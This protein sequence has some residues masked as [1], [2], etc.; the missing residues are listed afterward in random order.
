[1]WR[2]DLWDSVLFNVHLPL[3]KEK[4]KLN[5]IWIWKCG[6]KHLPSSISKVLRLSHKTPKK[7]EIWNVWSSIDITTQWGAVSFL[8]GKLVL[9]ERL[10]NKKSAF[11]T[12][13]VEIFLKIA[14]VL[15]ELPP[16]MK[17]NSNFL[18]LS[19]FSVIGVTVWGP[20]LSASFTRIPFLC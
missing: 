11:P 4:L 12:C 8:E 1:M 16:F 3:K 19:L 9:I 6:Q 17:A 20:S 7:S 14:V 15:W 2:G 13:I 10:A 5:W 18:C